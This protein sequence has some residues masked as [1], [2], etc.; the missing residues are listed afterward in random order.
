MKHVLRCVRQGFHALDSRFPSLVWPFALSFFKLYAAS[1]RFSQRKPNAIDVLPWPIPLHEPVRQIRIACIL[2]EFS[3]GCFAPEAEFIHLSAKCW[4]REIEADRPDFLLVE[5]AWR[6]L[7]GDWHLLI[8]HYSR[9]RR[10][11]LRDLLG[12]CRENGVKTVFWNKEDPPNFDHFIDAAKDF[13]HIFTTDADCITRYREICGH[14]RIHALPF[15]AG[16]TIHNPVRSDATALRAD[17]C[18]AGTWYG[19]KFPERCKTLTMM[20]DAALKY[21]LHIFDRKYGHPG[22]RYRFPARFQS[23]I[24]GSMSYDRML[25]AFRA[26]RVFLNTNSVMTSP[27]MFARRVFELLACGTPVVS[28]PSRGMEAMLGDFVRAAWQRSFGTKKTR[29]ISIP[30]SRLLECA[31]SFSRPRSTK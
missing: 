28:S 4:Q 14:D 18:F 24:K 12:W 8:S 10:N 1:A 5:S 25:T 2:D 13:D 16:P 22:A 6:G 17:V 9:F 15:A 21:D 7:A 20:L 11:P 31:I 23:R 19:D 26:Y 29:S 30:S 3:A 27:T